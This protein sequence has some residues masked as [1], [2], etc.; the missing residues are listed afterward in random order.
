MKHDCINSTKSRV[1]DTSYRKIKVNGKTYRHHRYAY[2]VANGLSMEEL[3]GWMVRHKCDNPACINPAH[4]ELGTQEDNMRD[5]AERGRTRG[6]ARKLSDAEVAEIRAATREP[7]D[8]L[9]AK[10]GVCRVTIH[11]VLNRLGAYK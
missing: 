6:V 4:L 5:R 9:A 10:Y 8:A 2:A 11:A 1:G 3:A 7:H